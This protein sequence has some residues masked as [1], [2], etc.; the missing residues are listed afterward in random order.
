MLAHQG[1]W[2]S[3]RM[4][5]FMRIVNHTRSFSAYSSSTA[6]AH[7]GQSFHLKP[8]ETL[9]QTG[10]VAVAVSGGCDSMAAVSLLKSWAQQFQRNVGGSLEVV[11]LVVDHQLREKSGEE[12]AQVQAWLTDMG[13]SSHILPLAWPVMGRRSLAAARDMRYNVLA[14]W[15]REQGHNA[16]FTGH[17]STDVAETFLQVANPLEENL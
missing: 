15:C 8:Y 12:A 17:H 16:I 4:L 9:L 6:L 5:F 10:R 3:A 2:N 14:E 1:G 7:D 11:G 13:V